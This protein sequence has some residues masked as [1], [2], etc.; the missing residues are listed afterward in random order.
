MDVTGIQ[1]IDVW[2]DAARPLLTY[3]ALDRNYCQFSSRGDLGLQLKYVKLQI[4]VKW[5]G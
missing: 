2:Y 1:N 3:A 4:L 5:S